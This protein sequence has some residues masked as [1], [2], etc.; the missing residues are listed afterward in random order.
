MTDSSICEHVISLLVSFARRRGEAC[1][2]VCHAPSGTAPNN[3]PSGVLV[4]KLSRAGQA[5][6]G[7]MRKFLPGVTRV[8]TCSEPLD[9]VEKRLTPYLTRELSGA[10]DLWFTITCPGYTDKELL[11]VD[12][13]LSCSRSRGW[14]LNM[15]VCGESVLPPASGGEK[16]EDVRAQFPLTESPSS[17]DRKCWQRRVK[18][19]LDQQDA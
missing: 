5:Y 17:L 15:V 8:E 7:E 13:V 16:P 18:S 1:L 11:V 3:Q 9:F 12:G 14:G 19:E 6:L 2:S 4:I 10:C